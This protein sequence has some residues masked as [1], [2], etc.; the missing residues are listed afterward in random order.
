MSLA[1]LFAMATQFFR[2]ANGVFRNKWH[3][4]EFSNTKND[5]FQCFPS[6]SKLL[7]GD[8]F[9]NHLTCPTQAFAFETNTALAGLGLFQAIVRYHTR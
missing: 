7:Q 2:P 1:H 3:D 5:C 6:T 4:V 8:T 9:P